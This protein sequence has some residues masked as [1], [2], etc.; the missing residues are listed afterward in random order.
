MAT[1]GIVTRVESIT[2]GDAE[3]YLK[4]NLN[5]RPVS[6][7]RVNTLADAIRRGE[8]KIT[9][10]SIKFCPDGYLLDGQHR[11]HACVLAGLPVNTCVTRNVPKASFDAMDQG[12]SRTAAQILA[13]KGVKNYSHVASAVR[14]AMLIEANPNNP[15]FS[16]IVTPQQVEAYLHKNAG[17]EQWVQKS[18]GCKLVSDSPVVAALAYLFSKKNPALANEFVERLIDG[19]NLVQHHPIVTLR[20]RLI[21]NKASVAKLPRR[22]VIIFIIKAWNAMREGN[23]LKLLRHTEVENFPVII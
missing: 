11:L 7:K 22:L 3:R 12:A 20:D 21:Q 1:Q 4:L 2:P 5:N 8:W 16:T 10:E 17:I 15:V 19:A 6:I 18:R 14:T 9:G 23:K 13:I